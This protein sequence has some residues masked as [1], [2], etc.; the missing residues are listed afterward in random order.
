MKCFILAV[1]LILMDVV[2]PKGCLGNG[3]LSLP[4]IL[5]LG[6]LLMVVVTLLSYSVN[7]EIQNN[8]K[9]VK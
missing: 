5:A 2:D 7:R 3:N 8:K 9:S 4:W 1:V 6:C